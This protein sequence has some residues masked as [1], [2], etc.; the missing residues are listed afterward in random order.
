[1]T[2]ESSSPTRTLGLTGIRV[3]VL[4]LGTGGLG[5]PQLSEDQ[6]GT[7]LNRAVDFGLH[8]ID[9]APSYGLAEERIGRHLSWRRDD[10]VLVTKVGYGVPGVPDWTFAAI[11]RGIPRAL[12]RMRTQRLDVV[13]LHS[14][15]L[16]ILRRPE[17][18]QALLAA[19]QAG[20]VRAIGY[21]GENEALAQAIEQPWCEVIEVSVNPFDQRVLDD[22]L[23]RAKAR[24]LGVL[25]KRPLGNAPWRFAE[26][27]VGDYAEVYWSRRA[28]MALPLSMP[29]DEHALRFS[30]F[31][32]GV[33]C[34]IFGT[35]SAE[36][37]EAA[38]GIIQAGPLDPTTWATARA[39]FRV[40]DRGWVGQV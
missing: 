13:L 5:D 32:P 34:A 9:A 20:L 10:F 40:H 4:G 15:P 31:A 26:R 39:H 23:P 30:A 6:V 8:L 17:L 16:E 1:M 3:P 36:R 29:E 2:P 24:G 25:A 12:E 38:A 18:G 22:L 37:V 28:A 33:D 11:E 27:P 7:V 14:C 35:R 21:S 19:K